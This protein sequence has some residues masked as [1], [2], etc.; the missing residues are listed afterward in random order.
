MAKKKWDENKVS[1]DESGRFVSWSMDIQVGGQR[2]QRSGPDPSRPSAPAVQGNPYG[3]RYAPGMTPAHQNMIDMKRQ[4][5]EKMWRNQQN[6]TVN[7]TTL[8]SAKPKRRSR[9]KLA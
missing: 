6:N 2:I 8:S 9:G 1:R 5:D 3:N 4:L 7:R